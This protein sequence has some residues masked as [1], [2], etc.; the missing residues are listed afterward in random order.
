MA[1]SRSNFPSVLLASIRGLSCASYS[2]DCSVISSAAKFLSVKSHSADVNDFPEDSR[3]YL[4]IIRIIL[5]M[6]KL[7]LFS[8]YFNN[9]EMTLTIFG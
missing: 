5:T 9:L 3:R 2:G 8:N 7:E 1:Q 4:N 6:M